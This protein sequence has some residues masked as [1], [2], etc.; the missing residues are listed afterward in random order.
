MQ[1][2][3]ATL[4]AQPNPLDENH[5]KWADYIGYTEWLRNRICVHLEVSLN[6]PW[7]EL[8][9]ITGALIDEEYLSLEEAE[10][11][12]KFGQNQR[13]HD[14]LVGAMFEVFESEIKPR[15]VNRI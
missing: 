9:K 4:Y 3:W 5:P 1:V 10:K 6:T 13:L 8:S 7:E 14:K 12:R 11:A 2:A 15:I